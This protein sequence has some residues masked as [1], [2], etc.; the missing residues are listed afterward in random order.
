MHVE[1]DCSAAKVARK[2]RYLKSELVE[3]KERAAILDMQYR[4]C[5]RCKEKL[6]AKRGPIGQAPSR[7]TYRKRSQKP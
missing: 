1:Q 7:P 5:D 6:E 3:T 4:A 2:Y